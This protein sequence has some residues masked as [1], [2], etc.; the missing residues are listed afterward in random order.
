MMTDPLNPL[1]VGFLSPG[2]LSPSRRVYA[3]G[4]VHG[5]AS[6]L[7][8]LHDAILADLAVDPVA[9]PLLIHLGDYVDRGANS[10]GTVR[11]L[12]GGPV[13]PG[14]PM[15]CLRGNHEQMMLDALTGARAHTRLWLANG[16]EQTLQSW[17]VSP[18]ADVSRWREAVEREMP[19]LW[20]L[21]SFYRVD[22]Y[23]FVHA[24][25]RPG[26]DLARQSDQDLLW[27]REGFLDWGGVLFPEALDTAVVHG[28]TP[29]RAPE[30]AGLRIGID[31][32]AVMG[33]DLTC[34][35]LQN[36]TVRFITA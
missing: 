5:C 34:A 23:V 27:I 32:G 3:I 26:V 28:H 24:G 20:S 7:N 25:V 17:G 36:R 22:N 9:K 13:I 11:R 8:D 12:A 10:A 6:R 33:G 35:V 4:D 18:S 15:V 1:D 14:V 16:G 2:Y 31:T 30:I 19:F 29:T 21:P